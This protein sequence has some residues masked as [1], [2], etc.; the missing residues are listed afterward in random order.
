MLV[1]YRY[2]VGARTLSSD[3]GISIVRGKGGNAKGDAK[4]SY[5][6]I[7]EA[8]KLPFNTALATGII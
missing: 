4:C 3:V 2:S 7:N 1:L 6:E 8:T 5:H